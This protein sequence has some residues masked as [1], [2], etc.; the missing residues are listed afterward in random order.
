MA[1][2]PDASI[3]AAWLLPDE[4]AALADLAPDRLASETPA[5]WPLVT[6]RGET[7]YTAACALFTS[8][9]R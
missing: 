4:S 7:G 1:F 6:P 9:W 3:A 5:R 2:V 8:R